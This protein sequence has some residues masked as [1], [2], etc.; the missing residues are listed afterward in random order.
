M[1]KITEFSGHTFEDE[2]SLEEAKK[3]AEAIEY[4]KAKTDLTNPEV[5]L[6]LYIRLLDRETLKTPVGMDFLV[7][8]RGKIIESGV[9]SDE[10]LKPVPTYK[11][12][13]KKLIKNKKQRAE[14]EVKKL[15]GLVSV[16]GIVCAFLGFMVIGM[17]VM[18]LTG[19]TSPARR[20]YEEQILDKYASWA[21]DL[22]SK[23]VELREIIKNINEQGI[24]VNFE[25]L[26][27]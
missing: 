15:R 12:E 27:E 3:E 21:E 26:G 20:V 16:L 17:F 9:I 4:L 2:E 22:N 25:S 7:E 14:D 10:L 6:R 24:D 19:Y 13:T 1:G 5:M 18:A 23:E 8:L 11:G